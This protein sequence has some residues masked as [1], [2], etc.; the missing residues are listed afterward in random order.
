MGLPH[1]PSQTCVF[2]FWEH[3]SNA[4]RGQAS[5]AIKL[6]YLSRSCDREQK[7]KRRD[8]RL[9]PCVSRPRSRY[10][11]SDARL[12]C[13]WIQRACDRGGPLP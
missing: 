6:V 5:K 13:L 12:E 1:K 10:E 2:H 4:S 9:G 11:G 8:R 3:A 7:E